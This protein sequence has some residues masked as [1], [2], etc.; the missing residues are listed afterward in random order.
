LIKAVTVIVV[1]AIVTVALIGQSSDRL[2]MVVGGR[3]IISV[4][5][6]TVPRFG[7]LFVVELVHVVVVALAHLATMPMTKR[8]KYIG[9]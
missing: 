3:V 7:I 5:V 9:A 8:R 1:E 6:E 2:V 4:T